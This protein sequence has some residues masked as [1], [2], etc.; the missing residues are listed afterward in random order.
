MEASCWQNRGGN[1]FYFLRSRL[2]IL[3]LVRSCS[4]FLLWALNVQC[5]FRNRLLNCFSMEKGAKTVLQLKF[6][7]LCSDQVGPLNHLVAHWI[8][9]CNRTVVHVLYLRYS[10]SEESGCASCPTSDAAA[11]VDVAA[12]LLILHRHL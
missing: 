3:W 4:A 7:N 6:L 10:S 9:L 8:R 5:F 1:N 11:C 12:S 2:E